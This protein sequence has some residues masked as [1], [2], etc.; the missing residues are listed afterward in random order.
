MEP[1]L[2]PTVD[3]LLRDADRA[4]HDLDLDSALAAYQEACSLDPTSYDAQ[5]GTARTFSRMRRRDEALAACDRCVALDPDRYE[6]YAAR[7]T[8]HFLAD[9]LDAAE[10]ASRAALERAHDK[11][12]PWLTLAQIFVDRKDFVAAD[13]HIAEARSR[14][15]ALPEGSERD[16]LIAMAWHVET[17][18]HLLAN[19]ANAAREAAQHVIEMEEA[20]PYAAALA[21]SNLGIMETR[22]RHY[23]AAIEYL[24]R[25]YQTNPHFYRAAGALGRVLI[26]RNQHA[27]AAEVLE[28]VM[29]HEEGDSG[30][31]RYAYAVALAKSGRREEARAQYRLALTRGLKGPLWILAWWQVL[32]LYNPVRYAIAAVAAALLLAWILIGQPSQQAITLIVLVL[33]MVVLQK[34]LAKRR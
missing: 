2:Q 10:G 5:L 25:A 21:Y 29:S 9:E 32:W 19:N 31:A 33:V 13:R 17:Y 3:S 6:A 30:D 20:S 22:A 11:P 24:E 1:A 34:V 27:R 14:I 18:R 23:D 16:E 4:Y 7:G 8:L 26:M 12:E 15:D 28:Q